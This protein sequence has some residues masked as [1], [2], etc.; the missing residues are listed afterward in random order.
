MSLQS[1][2]IWYKYCGGFLSH[3]EKQKKAKQALEE[4]G[5]SITESTIFPD[6]YANGTIWHKDQN[7]ILHFIHVSQLG[8]AYH[9]MHY[10]FDF[11]TPKVAIGDKLYWTNVPGEFFNGFVH[12]RRILGD[13]K[14]E[15][16]KFVVLDIVIE[17]IIIDSA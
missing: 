17:L 13:H 9:E 5:Y 2:L 16:T 11:P 8:K 10:G 6:G 12:E 7:G 14:K 15:K 4:K 1:E 3:I